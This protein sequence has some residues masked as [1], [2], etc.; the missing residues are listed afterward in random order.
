LKSGAGAGSVELDEQDLFGTL[1]ITGS[2]PD[3]DSET[4]SNMAD[5]AAQKK[6]SA[7]VVL[8][9]ASNGKVT[10]VAKATPDLV[11]RGIHAGNLVREVA[12]I[13][14]GGGG[15]RPDFAQAGGKDPAKLS[16][17]LAAVPA[18]VKQQTDTQ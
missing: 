18:L 10:F 16:D 7:I 8:G 6:G 9:S 11:K 2:I 5:R 17:A 4:L 13:A 3:A 15:G 1:L 12:K 14:G